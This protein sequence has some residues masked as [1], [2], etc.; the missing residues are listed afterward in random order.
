[1]TP[2]K[3]V[4][5]MLML[6]CW[7]KYSLTT[8]TSPEK[9]SYHLILLYLYFRIIKFSSCLFAVTPRHGICAFMPEV[10]WILDTI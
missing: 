8:I 9:I 6:G 4:Q 5:F 2:W 10:L 1:M 7:S 3:L